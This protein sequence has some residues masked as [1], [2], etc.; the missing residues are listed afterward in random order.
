VDYF[1][2]WIPQGD[3]ITADLFNAPNL[4]AD[5]AL[6]L[7]LDPANPP[8]ASSDRADQQAEQ[9]VYYSNWSDTYYLK[10]FGSGPSDF[11][12]SVPYLL[13]A[14]AGAPTP[15]TTPGCPDTEPND[16]FAQAGLAPSGANFTSYICT[17][18]DLDYWKIPG[19]SLG[20]IIQ[21]NLTELPQD[22]D[23]LLYRPQQTMA[24]Q[25]TTRG[26]GNET[27]E[28]T[29]DVEG[30]YWY[31]LVYG[32]LGAHDDINPY[33]LA[34]YGVRRPD[35]RARPIGAQLRRRPRHC[36]HQRGQHHGDQIEP[37]HLPRWRCGL[38]LSES[39]QGW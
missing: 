22:Y 9:I 23:L 2:L 11:N 30:E 29:T 13:R 21:V 6:E 36:L 14:T 7:Y 39:G 33:R 10:V 17:S 24:A 26:T 16:S 28:Y 18:T 8:V 3:T 1:S 5:Y 34:V 25:S 12:V 38:V 15:T 4:P 35:L 37:E 32:H 20:Q 31:I 27:I 19:V